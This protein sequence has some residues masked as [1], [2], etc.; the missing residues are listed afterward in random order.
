MRFDTITNN[1]VS[2]KAPM[3][4][5]VVRGARY[6]VSGEIQYTFDIITPC[7][8]MIRLGHFRELVPK[9][10]GIADT[11]PAAQENDSRT[12][13][14]NPY[15]DVAAGEEIATKVGT[16]KDG[17]T[18]FDFG[19]YDL[20]QKNVASQNPTYAAAHSNDVELAQHALCWFG[21]MSATDKAIIAKLPAGD[22]TSG[23]SSDYCTAADLAL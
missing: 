22:P 18:F 10:Q 4:G 16:T 21:Y 13:Y 17:N 6:L 8:F 3:S 7:G 11:F 15:V 1:M 19:L 14:L 12:T 9:F 2:V 23:K 20:K 5:Q